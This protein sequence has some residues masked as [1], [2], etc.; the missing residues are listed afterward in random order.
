LFFDKL[1][2]KF[3][4]VVIFFSGHFIIQELHLNSDYFKKKIYHEKE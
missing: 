4:K 1:S 3:N 2:Q